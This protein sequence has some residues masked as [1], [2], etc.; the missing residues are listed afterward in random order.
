M[1]ISV[2]SLLL[3]CNE[4]KIYY[5]RFQCTNSIS[6]DSPVYLNTLV[7]G[8]V[9]DISKSLDCRDCIRIAVD[10]N[11]IFTS[12]STVNLYHIDIYGNT[13]LRIENAFLKDSIQKIEVF[14]VI[15]QD[16]NSNIKDITLPFNLKK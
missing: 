15:C 10:K 7:V 12:S 14:N 16:H 11:V 8:R 1:I 5:C 4:R 6:I 9:I 2:S 13:A 3:S